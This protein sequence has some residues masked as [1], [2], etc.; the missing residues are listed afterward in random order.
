MAAY[1]I[2]LLRAQ[3]PRGPYFLGG[4]CYGG[5][6]AVEMAHQL[7]AA[8]Q[9]VAPLF[10]IETPAPAPSLR[11]WI[12]FLRRLGCALN[13]TPRDWHIYLREKARY[14]RGIQNAN[15]KRFQRVSTD[16]GLAER[17]MEEQNRLLEQLETVYEPNLRALDFYKSRF[18][19]GKIILFN[20]DEPDPALVRDPK[21]G[22]LGLAAEI[23]IHVISGGHDTVLMEPHV[24]MLAAKM[25]ECLHK[26]QTNLG[27]E[28][29]Q[30]IS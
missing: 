5:I 14:Y 20:A 15:E 29:R 19:P 13:M 22:W 27:V 24:Q 21:Y 11:N 18:Y 9:S 17:E 7:L 28:N 12:Y 6:V 10:L 1:Y 16:D 23:E 26:I 8:G 2:Q 4:W 25:T 3:Q 30:T